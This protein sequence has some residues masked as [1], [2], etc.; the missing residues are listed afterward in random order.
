MSLHETTARAINPA[1]QILPPAMD[2]PEARVMLLAIALQ[3][4]RLEYRRQLKGGPAR[5]LWQ[6]ER[7]SQASRGGV[8]G[9]FLHEAS[10]YWLSQ[11]C[12][13]RGIT[14]HPEYIYPVLERDDV[15]AAG[16]ARLLLFT[17]PQRLPAVHDAAGAWD[18]YARRTWRP[19]RPHRDTWDKFHA[20]ARAFVA[21]AGLHLGIQE[22]A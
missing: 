2:S 9:V 4:S 1:L 13:A 22:L 10:R 16:L 18:L 20:Q 21:D 8:W 15:L 17:D 5:G 6:F 3:E 7:G 12:A 19:G 14:F 11:L